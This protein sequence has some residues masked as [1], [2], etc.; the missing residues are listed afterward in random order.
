MG[1]EEHDSEGSVVVLCTLLLA[2][3]LAA[4]DTASLTG[5]IRDQTGAVLSEA[6]VVLVNA[7]TGLTRHFV[8]NSDGE[9]VA[10][11]LPP[12]RYALTVTVPGF[13]T[14]KADGV[15]LRVAQNARID[16]TMHVGSVDSDITVQGEGLAQVDTQSSELSGTVT[17]KEMVQL[18]LN[19][20]NFTQLVTLIPGVSNQTGQDRG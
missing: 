18:P 5:T 2:R 14:Y 16:V 19:G 11:A 4:Q 8:T 10:P 13:R 15:I 1:N 9:Y 20:R 7:A 3:G 17:G 6:G 12:G